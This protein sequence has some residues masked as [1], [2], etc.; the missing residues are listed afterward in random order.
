MGDT[1]QFIFWD[2][3]MFRAAKQYQAAL[4]PLLSGPEYGRILYM[5]SE[6]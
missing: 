1:N 2:P 6:K 3:Q 5:F 4:A